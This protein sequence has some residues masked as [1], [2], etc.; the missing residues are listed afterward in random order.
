[1]NFQCSYTIFLTQQK[2]TVAVFINFL[3]CQPNIRIEGRKK[4][5]ILFSFQADSNGDHKGYISIYF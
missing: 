2:Y 4:K 1:M 5:I 3:I